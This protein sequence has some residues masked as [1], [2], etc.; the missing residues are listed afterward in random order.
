MS[1]IRRYFRNGNVYFL[2]HVT[3]NRLSVLVDNFDLWRR[4]VDTMRANLPFDLIAWVVL[5]DHFHVIIDP[6]RNNL[7]SLVKRIKL[8]FSANYR[9]RAGVV[10]GRVWQYRFWDHIIRD[11]DDLSRHIDYVHYNPVKHGLVRSPFQWEY[12]SIHKYREN[13][14]Y[15]ADWG[16]SDALDIAGEFGE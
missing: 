4:A 15:A 3:Y 6:E 2:T 14:Y 13:G 11:G 1:D 9:R 10:R 7:S 5:P 16:V 8:S 12:S